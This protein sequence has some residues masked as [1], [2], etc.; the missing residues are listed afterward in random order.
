MSFND[1]LMLLVGVPVVLAWM[2]FACLVIWYGLHSSAV[3]V[4]IKD[5]T[6]LIAIIGGPALLILTSILE[7]WKNEQNQE[8][9]SM[10][11]YWQHQNT[12]IQNQAAHLRMVE[13]KN[14]SHEQVLEAERQAVALGLI[15]PDTDPAAERGEEAKSQTVENPT[16]EELDAIDE[17]ESL[18]IENLSE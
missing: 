12:D 7:L 2:G 16:V 18:D 10:P 9:S 4:N 15:G 13:T 3:L 8:I 14:Q 17:L 1:R 11:E 5:Y 6:T